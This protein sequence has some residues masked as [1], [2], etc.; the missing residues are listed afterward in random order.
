MVGGETLLIVGASARA[1]AFSALRAGWRPWCADLFNDA[2]LTACCPTA[3]LEPGTYPRG[4]LAAVAQGPPGPLIYTG[5]LENHPGLIR[6]LSRERTLW[7]N[8]GRVLR[9]V[10]SPRT[11]ASIFQ[12]GGIPHPA[13]YFRADD[14]ADQGRWL[15]K[16]LAGA[17]GA[18]IRFWDRLEPP[19]GK[20]RYFQ[21]WMEGDPCSAVFAG[22]G[23]A[24]RLLGVTRQLVG[25]PWLHAGPFAYCG[26]IGPLAVSPPVQSHLECLGD[27]LV[28]G[29]GMRGL[30]GVDFIL[31]DN[32]PWPVEV[33]PRYTASVE[34]LEYARGLSALAIHGKCFDPGVSALAKV[35]EP[36]SSD[37]PPF[38]VGKGILFASGLVIFPGKGPWSETIEELRAARRDADWWELPAFADIPPPGQRVNPGRPI[39]TFFCR[40][41]SVNGCREG[42]RQMAAD[43]DRRLGNGP[44][45]KEKI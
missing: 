36:P 45:A 37:P 1:A 34:V 18:G 33:N 13:V 20:R 35:G 39:L 40:A 31:Q 28:K 27:A 16:P 12:G 24:A 23:L 8:D 6:Q 43:L 38:F 19:K 14:I 11:L 29:S 7:G 2:D 44:R 22:D 41:E 5:G 21:Q 25:E 26:S 4:L 32:A 17:G 15:I 30:F 9:A 42:L 10:R 3:P